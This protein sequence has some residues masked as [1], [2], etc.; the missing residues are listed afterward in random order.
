MKQNLKIFGPNL[1][2]SDTSFIV[3]ESSC[4]HCNRLAGEDGWEMT[5]VESKLE[6]SECIWADMIDEGSTTAESGLND[7]HFCPCVKVP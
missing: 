7:I 6:V 2:N 4:S 3:H 5:G 1:R